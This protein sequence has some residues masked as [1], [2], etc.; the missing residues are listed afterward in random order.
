MTK[1]NKRKFQ[2]DARGNMFLQQDGPNSFQEIDPQRSNNG[3]QTE[4]FQPEGRKSYND[5]AK[6]GDQQQR[7]HSNRNG[8]HNQPGGSFGNNDTSEEYI[9]NQNENFQPG[10]RESNNDTAK[11]G[12]QQQREYNYRNGNQPGGRFQQRDGFEKQFRDDGNSFSKAG[13]NIQRLASLELC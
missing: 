3:I 9:W 11:Q 6:Q 4:S 12:D 1:D 10:G 5:A 7:E 2:P 13:K 8:N